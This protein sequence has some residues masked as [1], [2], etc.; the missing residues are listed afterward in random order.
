MKVR[1]KKVKRTCGCNPAEYYE[2]RLLQ[3][4]IRLQEVP[5]SMLRG[6]S[7]W[8]LYV[9]A[10]RI[11]RAVS[12]SR[13][14]E[15]LAFFKIELDRAILQKCVLAEIL[16]TLYNQKVEEYQDFFGKNYMR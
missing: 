4:K 7:A 15:D 9:T 14:L 2:M 6:E 16:K 1:V 3:N 8:S 5:I 12:Q 13:Y 11:D 10:F